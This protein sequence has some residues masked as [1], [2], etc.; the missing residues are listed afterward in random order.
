[1]TRLK[2]LT[3]VWGQERVKH[4]R[5]VARYLNLTLPLPSVRLTPTPSSNNQALSPVASA[6]CML[7]MCASVWLGWSSVASSG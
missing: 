5:Q 7:T 2:M 3:L 4:K 1:M 6:H